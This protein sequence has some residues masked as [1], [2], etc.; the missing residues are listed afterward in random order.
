MKET[1]FY[2]EICA[3][4][5]NYLNSYLPSG[6]SIFYSYNKAFNLMVEE[7][8]N[9]AGIELNTIKGYLPK[10]KLDILFGIKLEKTEELRFLLLEVK[11]LPQLSLA[12]F[13]QLIGYLQVARRIRIGI[14]FL[15][16]KPDSQIPLSNDFDEIIQTHNL[17][18]N[19]KMIVEKLGNSIYH[20]KTGISYFIP[21]NGVEWVDTRLIGGISDFEELTKEIVRQ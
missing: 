11:Y 7:I 12:D 5:A 1:D 15:V 14:L 18:M 13:S 4:F 6:T 10:L 2:P 3:R 20:F 17:P 8:Q 9:A 19:W 21:N 16:I